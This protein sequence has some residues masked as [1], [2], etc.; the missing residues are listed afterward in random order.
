MCSVSHII[1]SGIIRRKWKDS[2]AE[3]F[4]DTK[5]HCYKMPLVYHFLYQYWIFKEFY[6]T[7][8][9]IKPS[10][11]CFG[12]TSRFNHELYQQPLAHCSAIC[13]GP[14]ERKLFYMKTLKM[15]LSS[16]PQQPLW[17]ALLCFL[18]IVIHY[19][20]MPWTS[21]HG[22]D[23]NTLN[24][25]RS[26]CY[27]S[28]FPLPCSLVQMTPIFSK[29]IKLTTTQFPVLTSSVSF[30]RSSHSFCMSFLPICTHHFYLG[31]GVHYHSL[32]VFQNNMG[33]GLRLHRQTFPAHVPLMCTWKM[34]LFVF[35]IKTI[36]LT[37]KDSVA[38]LPLLGPGAG[39]LMS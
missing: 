36:L 8:W 33:W 18:Y 17:R 24:P 12:F 29:A 22:W 23:T 19:F 39:M 38:S 37:K 2:I 30:S 26:Q 28:S 35:W 25:P 27:H 9:G 5:M 34:L 11:G 10:P 7:V 15:Q 31:C 32:Y 13:V 6:T 14:K 16:K 1:F 3:F 20:F 21:P 4:T